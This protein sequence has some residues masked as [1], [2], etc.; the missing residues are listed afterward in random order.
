M[1][2]HG[3]CFGGCF[4]TSLGNITTIGSKPPNH[5]QLSAGWSTRHLETRLS[6]PSCCGIPASTPCRSKIYIVA[7]VFFKYCGLSCKP[8]NLLLTPKCYQFVVQKA[9]T[10][11]TKRTLLNVGDF[12][13]Q[14]Q[15]EFSQKLG[16]VRVETFPN[17][18]CFSRNCFLTNTRTTNG[19]LVRIS[20]SNNPFYQGFIR[21]G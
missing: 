9:I 3:V 11:T 12:F 4:S 5:H 20:L 10:I 8:Q 6:E 14:F 1:D 21:I 13:A 15:S 18:A 19:W 17:E 2:R 16:S 7:I